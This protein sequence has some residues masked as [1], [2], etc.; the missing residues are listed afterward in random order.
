MSWEDREKATRARRGAPSEEERR[1]AAEARANAEMARLC[2]A[3]FATGQGRELLASL[4]RRTKD[5][6]L[7]PDASASA[8]FHLEGQRQ[9]VHAI[10]TWTA[11]G[12]RTDPSDLRAGLAGT[13]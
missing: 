10:E 2:A 9:L 8:L 13:D 1:A 6:V 4:R 7:G 3:V 5:R 12:T 11:D